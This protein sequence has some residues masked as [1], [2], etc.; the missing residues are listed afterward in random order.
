MTRTAAVDAVL[1]ACPHTSVPRPSVPPASAPSAV[2]PGT[3]A[4]GAVASRAVASHAAAGPGGRRSAPAAWPGRAHPPLVRP[5][6]ALPYPP[7]FMSA[8]P[9]WRPLVGNA[10]T[11]AGW[12]ADPGRDIR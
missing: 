11:L 2:V 5:S 4:A 3:V 7:G 6:P 9:H 10:E 1:P 12:P 8:G